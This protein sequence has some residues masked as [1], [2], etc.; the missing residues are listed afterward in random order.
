MITYA[1]SLPNQTSLKTLAYKQKIT[2]YLQIS[3][4]ALTK[5][6]RNLLL[7]LTFP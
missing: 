1:Q 2:L 4:K 5:G 7:G 6:Q 3:E